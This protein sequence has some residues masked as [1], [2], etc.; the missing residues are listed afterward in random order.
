ME[1]DEFDYLKADFKNLIISSI[2][3]ADENP[4]EYYLTE[5]YNKEGS[6]LSKELIFC[7][8]FHNNFGLDAAFAKSDIAN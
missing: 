8:L 6:I 2:E 1:V 4:A 3:S 5:N 7:Q